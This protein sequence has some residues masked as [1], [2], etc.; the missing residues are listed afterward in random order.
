MYDII[1][2]DI[3]MTGKEQYQVLIS[4]LY[5]LHYHLPELFLHHC[6]FKINPLMIGLRK[7]KKCFQNEELFV[8]PAQLE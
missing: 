7:M 2:Q 1:Q 6:Y 3:D 8:Y 5:K 4:K